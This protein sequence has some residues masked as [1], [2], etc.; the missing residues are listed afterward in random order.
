M[1]ITGVVVPVTTEIGAVP[2]TLVTV[3]VPLAGAQVKVPD[4]LLVNTPEVAF[5]AGKV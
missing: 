4:P 2:D 1:L 5:D 3:P